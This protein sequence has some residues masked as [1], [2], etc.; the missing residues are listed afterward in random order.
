MS[1]NLPEYNTGHSRSASSVRDLVFKMFR[2]RC[3]KCF[4]PGTEVHHIIPRSRGKV[5][6][7]VDNLV[8][9]CHKCHDKF[10]ELGASD[11]AIE[12]MQ[13]IRAQAIERW[14]GTA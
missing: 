7:S 14:L 11:N 13:I 3:A 9:L 8:L 1:E 5:S 2:G 4:K 12:Q 10:H 6:A